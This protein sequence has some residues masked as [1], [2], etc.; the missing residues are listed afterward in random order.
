MIE[1]DNSEYKAAAVDDDTLRL[2]YAFNGC[3]V[4]DKLLYE[5]PLHG[6]LNRSAYGNHQAR[7]EPDND[8]YCVNCASTREWRTEDHTTALA[9]AVQT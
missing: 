5:V 4:K 3:E 1:M 2:I 6:L 8:R 9:E 7:M